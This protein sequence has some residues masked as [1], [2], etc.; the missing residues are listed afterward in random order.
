MHFTQLG[1]LSALALQ[2]VALPAP[3]SHVVHERREVQ[4]QAW[5]KRDIIDPALVVPV[6]IGMTQ[7]NLENGHDLLMEVYV[8]LLLERFL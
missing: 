1:F 4:S 5:V 8:E 3:E 6:R 2:V 7:S